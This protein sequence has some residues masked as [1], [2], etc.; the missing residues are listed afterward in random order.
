MLYTLSE[1]ILFIEF[2][3]KNIVR[4]IIECIM[5]SVNKKYRYIYIRINR[6]RNDKVEIEGISSEYLLF[7]YVDK[8][9]NIYTYVGD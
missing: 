3:G 5:K 7:L 8:K 6:S 1:N 2:I 9:I 4:T